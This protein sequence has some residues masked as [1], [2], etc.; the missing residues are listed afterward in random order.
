MRLVFLGPP[1]AGKGT[2]AE[3][4]A[5]RFNL[6]HLSTGDILR[7]AITEQTELGRRVAA[8]LDRGDLV[9]DETMI[10]LISDHI[11]A[12]S[13]FILDGFPRTLAQGHG[14]R[15]VLDQMGRPLSGV[16]LFNVDQAAMLE[17]IKRRQGEENRGDDTPE[18][19]LRRLKVYEAQTSP[20][21]AFYR[22]E[23]VLRPIDGMAG[24]EAVAQTI[25]QILERLEND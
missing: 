22:A 19:F 3:R 6:T 8:I 18:T 20:L 7:Q 24:I 13:G 23:G 12:A 17:R 16:I 25:A 1:G 14:L 21:L 10:D 4:A 9:D 5:K 15:A 11:E 2:Q